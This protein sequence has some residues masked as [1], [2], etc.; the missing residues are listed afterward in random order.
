MHEVLDHIYLA[1]ELQPVPLASSL[2]SSK[3]EH[4]RAPDDSQK[5]LAEFQ[6]TTPL[7]PPRFKSLSPHTSVLP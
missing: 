4:S 1:S 3:A 2:K 6:S 7:Q 5:S